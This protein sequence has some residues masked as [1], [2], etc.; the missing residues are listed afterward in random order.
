ML[1]HKW[2]LKT[3]YYSLVNKKGVKDEDVDLPSDFSEEDDSECE[4]CKL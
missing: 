4:S 1:A 3:V 2:G